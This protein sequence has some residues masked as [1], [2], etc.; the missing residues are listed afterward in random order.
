[1]R[2]GHLFNAALLA[3]SNM[4]QSSMICN[5][6]HQECIYW[7][8]LWCWWQ[9]PS[10]R[11]LIQ[12]LSESN[13]Q[14]PHSDKQNNRIMQNMGELTTKA[15]VRLRNLHLN[16]SAISLHAVWRLFMAAVANSAANR[17]FVCK[18]ATLLMHLNNPT[19][20][21]P[22]EEICCCSGKI[23]GLTCKEAQPRSQQ[24][25]GARCQ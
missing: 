24:V 8:P 18:S 11:K 16:Q 17:Y 4:M 25:L 13:K 2:T 21:T 20:R 7:I 12:L 5:C 22:L 3:V 9:H 1:M 10:E 6:V 15:P 19:T 14:F 23:S